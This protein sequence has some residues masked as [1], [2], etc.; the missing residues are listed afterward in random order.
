MRRLAALVPVI[1]GVSI[2]VFLMLHL[3]PGDPARLAA[4]IEASAEDVENVRH[5]LGLDRPMIVQYANFVGRALTGDFGT[6]FRSRRPVIDEISSRYGNTLLLGGTALAI[7]IVLGGVTGV[8]SAV[9]KYGWID[10][11]CLLV[12]LIGISMPTFFFG[13]LLMLVFSVQLGL[14]PLAGN[15]SWAHLVLPAVTL[16]V[17]STAVISRITRSSL[18]E[19][20]EQ[21]YIRTAR[22]KGLGEAVII[23]RH[24]LRNALIPIVTVVGLQLGYLLGGAVVTETVFAWPGVGRLVVQAISA[25]DFPVVQASVLVL[26]V[27]FVL[28]NLVTDLLY[29]LLDPRISQA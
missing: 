6:S 23:N 27:T 2:A 12:S 24:A 16:G 21:D 13:L 29:M 5:A 11:L 10:N 1:V 7:A 22:A 19:V 18:V 8:M 9:R 28:V 14:L 26:A 17:P 4:G 3:I 15:E 25:R 20:M